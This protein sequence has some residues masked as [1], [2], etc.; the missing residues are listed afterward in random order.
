MSLESSE[1]KCSYTS[2]PAPLSIKISLTTEDE[3][4]ILTRLLDPSEISLISSSTLNLQPLI[5][6]KSLPQTFKTTCQVT[7]ANGKSEISQTITLSE[8]KT[9][10]IVLS[11]VC[12][13]SFILVSICV[14]LVVMKRK[15]ASNTNRV[16]FS[17][18]EL[19]NSPMSARTASLNSGESSDYLKSNAVMTSTGYPGTSNGSINSHRDDGYYTDGNKH[20]HAL[21]VRAQ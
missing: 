2:F 3:Q 15:E 1:I 21:I 7:N 14:W 20:T 5:S 8:S 16:A 13:L 4:E 12:L 17:K 19:E 11:V 6:S 18:S 10:F 9:I